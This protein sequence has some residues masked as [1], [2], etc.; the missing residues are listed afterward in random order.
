[1]SKHILA[2]VSALI[3]TTSLSGAEGEK[4]TPLSPAHPWH[5]SGLTGQHDIAQV[6]RGFQ[7][8]WAKCAACHGM[9]FR[10]FW[11]LEKI[12]YSQGEVKNLINTYVTS[13][14]QSFDTSRYAIE[15][16]P[17]SRV[18]GAPDLTHGVLAK[19]KT[20]EKGSD[21]IYSLLLGYDRANDAVLGPAVRSEL[22]QDASAYAQVAAP[23]TAT[24]D[25]GAVKSITTR[26]EK[27]N[28]YLYAHDDQWV[29]RNFVDVRIDFQ[30]FDS[31]GQALPLVSTLSHRLD[32]TDPAHEAAYAEAHPDYTPPQTA[33]EAWAK[34]GQV[35][36]HEIA[37]CCQ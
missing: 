11:H 8:F 7:V 10:R 26:F 19:G 1:M 17:A 23:V 20:M 2:L 5:F 25:N 12:G 21:Y 36:F 37:S 28:F 27:P 4:A 3:L 31:Q 16:F 34:R 6:Q 22:N 24:F 14:G 33:E 32:E 29:L 35:H 9:E 30:E 13:Q 15:N 18:S